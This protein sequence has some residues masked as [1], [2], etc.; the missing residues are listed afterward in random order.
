M[1]TEKENIKSLNDENRRLDSAHGATKETLKSTTQLGTKRSALGNVTNTVEHSLLREPSK[2]GLKSSG[3]TT[4]HGLTTR[5]RNNAV[6]AAVSNPGPTAAAATRPQPVA[7]PCEAPPASFSARMAAQLDS[8]TDDVLVRDVS[9]IDEKDKSD[10]QLV[11][12][13]VND[14]F[15]Y[16]KEREIQETCPSNYM[17]GQNDISEKMR[18][19]LVDWL[20]EVHLKFKLVPE[21]L[22]L[23]VNVIDRFLA[24][25]PVTRQRLQLVGVTA[26]LISSKYEEIY[27]PE[28]RDF[29]YISDKAYTR[30]EILEMESTMLNVLGFNLSV[31]TALMFLPRF[32]KVAGLEKK[33]IQEL[34]NY[35]VE[36]TLQDYKYLKYVPSHLAAASLYLALK[37]SNHPWTPTLVQYTSYSDV[38]L[39]GC[40]KEME[41][42]ARAASTRTLTAVFKKYSL[43]KFSE[44]ARLIANAL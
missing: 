43:P 6:S 32:F 37:V 1:M 38:A 39:R 27:A 22:H 17:S 35:L 23:T 28:V 13:Y 29:V 14:I 11:S 10:A 16:L 8:S 21:T 19:I 44:A 42:T 25:R 3:A 24:Q 7:P 26:M 33:E 9:H 36:L 41:E 30:E 12:E 34:T 18:A 40:V 15:Y 4:R 2:K 31:P 20:V 5:P